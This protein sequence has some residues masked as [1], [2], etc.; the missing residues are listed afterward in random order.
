MSSEPWLGILAIGIAY[1]TRIGHERARSPLPDVAE[2]LAAVGDAVSVS[3]FAQIRRRAARKRCSPL[4]FRFTRQTSAR[5]AAEGAGLVPVDVH[6]REIAVQAH[7]FV[8][9]ALAPFSGTLDP[10]AGASSLIL[11]VPSLGRP[12]IAALIAA[13]A[14]EFQKLRIR[15]RR[16]GNAKGFQLHRVS[17]LFVVEMKSGIS[18]RAEQKLSAGQ[19]DVSV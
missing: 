18:R 1:E 17:P 15:H 11:P 9:A 12:E 7:L 6:D 19:L 2:H 10:V 13:V 16:P 4:P 5:I 8:E 3:E 14:N